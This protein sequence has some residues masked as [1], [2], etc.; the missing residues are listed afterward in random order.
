MG[1]KRLLKQRTVKR[2]SFIS[3][4]ELNLIEWGSRC[5]RSNFNL[6]KASKST[7]NVG[8]IQQQQ[9][10][11]RTSNAPAVCVCVCARFPVKSSSSEAGVDSNTHTRSDS[12]KIT[13]TSLTHAQPGMLVLFPKHTHTHTPSYYF[14]KHPNYK[15]VCA[16]RAKKGVT[17]CVC[18]QRC[19]CHACFLHV[20]VCMCVK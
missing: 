18:V 20:C 13:P 4:L 8:L 2:R 7:W 19:S 6:W 10:Q 12:Q 1:N 11:Q 3:G 17:E 9:Q 5:S 15:C 16:I 14:I